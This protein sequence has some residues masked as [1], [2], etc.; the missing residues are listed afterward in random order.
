MD[1]EEQLM[2]R[3]ISDCLKNCAQELKVLERDTSKLETVVSKEFVR[4]THKE[5]IEMLNEKF[6]QGT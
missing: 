5:V 1:F 3:I 6:D 2:K 4:L